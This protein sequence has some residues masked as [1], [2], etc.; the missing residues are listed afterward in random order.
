MSHGPGPGIN[1]LPSMLNLVINWR[2]KNVVP[3]MIRGQR[4][5]DGKVKLDI[6]LYPY[7]VKTGWSSESGFKP[8]DGP[9]GGVDRVAKQFRPS[10]SE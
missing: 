5:E 4:I 7:P 10:A 2:E 6:P 9:R 1:K 3:D 8:V